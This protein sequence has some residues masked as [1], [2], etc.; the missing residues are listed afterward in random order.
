MV[1]LVLVEEERE[2]WEELQ[3]EAGVGEGGGGAA[4]RSWGLPPRLR[5]CLWFR[6]LEL[7]TLCNERALSSIPTL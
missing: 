1:G 4:E 5:T 2:E 3:G 6:A 7:I